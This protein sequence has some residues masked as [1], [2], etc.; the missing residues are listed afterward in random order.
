MNEIEAEIDSAVDSLGIGAERW[1]KL[2]LD[3]SREICQT[4]KSRFVIGNPRAWWLGLREPAQSH[5][6]PKGDGCQFVHLYVPAEDERCW[7]IPETEEKDLPVYDVCVSELRRVLGE[8]RFF[9]YY[10]LS[11][12]YQWLI[13]ENDHNEVLVVRPSPSGVEAEA[14]QAGS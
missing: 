7:F 10:L 4:A 6:Y 5:S 1:R 13:V 12:R 11:N 9:E 3:Q 8:C 2:S 14:G